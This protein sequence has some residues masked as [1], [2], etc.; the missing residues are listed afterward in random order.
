MEKSSRLKEINMASHTS[1]LK[2]IDLRFMVGDMSQPKID[3][4]RCRLSD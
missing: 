4:F 1:N 2:L 3:Y